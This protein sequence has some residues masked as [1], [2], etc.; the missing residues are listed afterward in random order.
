MTWQEIIIYLALGAFVGIVA[1]LFGVGGGGVMV[2]SFTSLFALQHFPTEHLVHIALATSMAAII[3]T[4][5]A[6][7][8][9]HHAHGAVLW[10][11]V[12][13]ITPGILV[14]TL[15]LLFSVPIR[16]LTLSY[17]LYPLYGI[18]LVANVAQY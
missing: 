4:S 10:S 1:G 3:P 2:P 15:P 7:L 17:F 13:K 16:S 5:I 11:L 12:G 18:C 8:R 6:S 9:A 14:G